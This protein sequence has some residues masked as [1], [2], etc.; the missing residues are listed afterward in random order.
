M[1]YVTHVLQ[2]YPLGQIFY[3]PDTTPLLVGVAASQIGNVGGEP[4]WRWYGYTER[5]EWCACFVS[6]CANQC[7]YI[8]AGIIPKFSSCE[9]GVSWRKEHNQW[10]D[11]SITPTSGMLIFFDWVEESGSR[12]AEPTMLGLLQRLK[13]AGSIPLKGILGIAAENRAIR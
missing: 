6:W 11:R 1:D 4:Y 8:D 2:Y 7:G 12:D 9:W 5:V 10:A 13:T 3:D